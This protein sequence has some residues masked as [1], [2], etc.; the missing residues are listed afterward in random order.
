MQVYV[1]SRLPMAIGAA[2]FFRPLISISAI[3]T[4]AKNR[5]PAP[6]TKSAAI[7]PISSSAVAAICLPATSAPSSFASFPPS[8]LAN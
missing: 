2:P 6:P 5:R 7:S 1:L 4:R 3:T 8:L